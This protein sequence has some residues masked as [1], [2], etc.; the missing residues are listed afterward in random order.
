[1]AF[2]KAKDNALKML[3][4]GFKCKCIPEGSVNAVDVY[5]KSASTLLKTRRERSNSIL[6]VLN[7]SSCN[8]TS[9]M[10]LKLS[11]CQSCYC[12]Y[13]SI[14]RRTLQRRVAES[15]S[16][17]V[18]GAKGPIYRGTKSCN[19]ARPWLVKYAQRVGDPMPDVEEIHL[20]DYDWI[21]VY[22]SMVKEFKAHSPPTRFPHYSKFMDMRIKEFP[23][24]KI[25]KLKRF[26]KCKTCMDL[27]LAIAKAYG[28][29]RFQLKEE[30]NKH[31]LWQKNERAK[32]YKH[33]RKSMYLLACI[34][35][36]L[37]LSC[38]FKMHFYYCPK[39]QEFLDIFGLS[40]NSGIFGQPAYV[41]THNHM[42]CLFVCRES[43]K[44]SI[45]ISID[46]M[47]NY[48]S[49]FPRCAREDKKSDATE[50]LMCH[51]TGV[52]MHGRPNP[53]QVYTW[54]DRF[55]ASSDSIITILLDALDKTVTPTNPL[56]PTLYLHMDNC[57]RE[58]KNRYVLAVCNMLVAKGIF[59]KVKL[60]FLPVGHT[61][62]DCDQM[63]SRFNNTST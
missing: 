3:M 14:Q 44:E 52:L 36:Y 8:L 21:S 27:D 33:K 18:E 23:N 51:V 28:P 5:R 50:K 13:H 42:Q 61:H 46:S 41:T 48:K 60:S 45:T 59:K 15:R 34:L 17:W 32:Y 35:T 43:P 22:S 30:K 57:G 40:K 7:S 10:P 54:Y 62:D 37:L 12:K 19:D 16:G 11:L 25:R 31:I 6:A 58:N 4:N 38:Y 20:P 29:L 24:I 63:F 39:I 1:M 2:N 9:G 49:R 55:P 56:P 53:A 47:D 26:A